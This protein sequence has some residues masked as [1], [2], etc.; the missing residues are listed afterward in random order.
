MNQTE[1]AATGAGLSQCDRILAALESKR[2]HWV[3]MPDLARIAGG[4]AVHSR[5]AELRTRG[6]RIESMQ[7]R[8]GR[9]VWSFYRLEAE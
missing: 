5:I 9:K 6:H 1:H 8:R 2:G 3:A 4:Y 7:E